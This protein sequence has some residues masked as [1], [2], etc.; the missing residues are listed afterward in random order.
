M[1]FEIHLMIVYIIS[2]CSP[3]AILTN[4]MLRYCPTFTKRKHYYKWKKRYIPTPS[5]LAWPIF[6][7]H[8]S[9]LV[10]NFTLNIFFSGFLLG[11][12]RM[13]IPPSSNILMRIFILSK[14]LPS[15]IDISEKVFDFLNLTKHNG[16]KYCEVL[17]T[18]TSKTFQL[19]RF[20]SPG[21]TVKGTIKTS[22]LFSQTIDHIILLL[23][24]KFYILSFLVYGGKQTKKLHCKSHF[25]VR[26]P[27]CF[28]WSPQCH[29]TGNQY[30]LQSPHMWYS[31]T[32]YNK[33]T[34]LGGKKY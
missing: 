22:N 34:H 31:K 9:C 8:A 33:L 13:S 11:E 5:I 15:D 12:K 20:N 21:K 17:R 32:I 27:F 14:R 16:V 28:S 24:V 18:A 1:H 4:K 23:R 25:L 30:W 2:L 3:L 19:S 26:N 10:S 7:V 29:C 6:L